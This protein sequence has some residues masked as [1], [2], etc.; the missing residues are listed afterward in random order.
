MFTLQ[1]SRTSHTL[2]GIHNLYQDFLHH[3][4]SKVGSLWQSDNGGISGDWACFKGE[5]EHQTWVK[6]TSCIF[7]INHHRPREPFFIHPF[8]HNN[9]WEFWNRVCLPCLLLGVLSFRLGLSLFGTLFFS[10]FVFLFKNTLPKYQS[11]ELISVF[12]TKDRQMGSFF[13]TSSFLILTSADQKPWWQ[14]HVQRANP[15][16]TTV[17]CKQQFPYSIVSQD[18]FSCVVVFSW[19]FNGLIC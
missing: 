18:C 11:M 7:C 3:P 9:W 14:Q 8:P 2:T 1:K 4:H 16:V 13:L 15:H 5:V 19:V 6:K 17:G 10:H 12:D